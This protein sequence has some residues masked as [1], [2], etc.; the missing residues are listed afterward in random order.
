MPPLSRVVPQLGG[1]RTFGP[2]L[3]QPRASVAPSLGRP[4]HRPERAEARDSDL[5]SPIPVPEDLSSVFRGV[6]PPPG[7]SLGLTRRT[8]LQFPAE[9][10]SSPELSST[11]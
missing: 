7:G 2:S 9:V 10:K 1:D 11:S 4:G 5:S 6:G 8:L 3:L